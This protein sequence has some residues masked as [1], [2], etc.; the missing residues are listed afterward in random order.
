MKP[1]KVDESVPNN[2]QAVASAF[3]T[4]AP[5]QQPTQAPQSFPE[6]IPF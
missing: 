5:V 3:N 4:Q 1:F 6:D 2:V